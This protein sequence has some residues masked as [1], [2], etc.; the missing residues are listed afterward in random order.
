LAV[1]ETNSILQDG[2]DQIQL[3]VF[4]IVITWSIGLLP[5]LVFRYVILKRPIAI[6]PA[7]GTS[8]LFW[9]INIFLF[10]IMG[11]QS[12]RHGALALIATVSCWILR[13]GAARKAIN[14]STQTSGSSASFLADITP[15]NPTNTDRHITEGTPVS[16]PDMEANNASPAGQLEVS[17]AEDRIYAEIASELET[18]NIDIGIW[19]RL[20]AE[21]SGDEKQ[22]KVLYIKQRA[23]RL[24]SA[25]CIAA[26][27]IAAEKANTKRIIS[28]KRIAAEKAAAEKAEAE[29]IAAEK[30]KAERYFSEK[31]ASEKAAIERI[32]S[33]KAATELRKKAHAER[34]EAQRIADEKANA[35]LRKKT[36]LLIENQKRYLKKG[37]EHPKVE[38]TDAERIA[39]V[40]AEIAA[41]K[42]RI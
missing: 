20:F 22:M 30:A 35:E 10:T 12:K 25:E 26:E 7:I 34:V 9:L 19:T 32:A 15:P 29:R 38:K 40:N 13:Q 11:S 39:A 33:E 1:G 6:W 27:K 5:P 24:I 21:C 37:V 41:V 42:S 17:V 16:S 28:A 23:E 8:A 4:N 18:G 31:A 14:V 2:T 36:D 3:L